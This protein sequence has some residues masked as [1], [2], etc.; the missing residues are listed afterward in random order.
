MLNALT[1]DLEDYFH[2][3]AFAE[4]V[5]SNQ[6]NSCASRLQRNTDKVLALFASKNSKATF[7]VLGWVAERYPALIR[8]IAEQGHEIA[9]HSFQHKL[10][11]ELTAA[12]F[13]E[14]SRKAKALLEDISGTPV[15]GYRS[16]SFSINGESLWAFEI[17]AD[18]GFS[19]DSS[20]FPV[21]HLNYGMHHAARF[22]FLI[23][24]SSGSILEFPMPTLEFSGRRAPFGGGAYFRLLP[25]WYT[26]WA[27]QFVNA[28]EKAPISVYL[29]PWELD[30]EQPRMSG[31]LTARLRHYFGLRGMKRKLRQLLDDFHFCPMGLLVDQLALLGPKRVSPEGV[32]E[33]LGVAENWA[34]PLTSSKLLNRHGLG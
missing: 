33:I 11:Y 23:D 8:H 32:R 29:H 30:P 20:I 14:D 6:W 34:G 3:T 25:Y 19:Y 2:V 4:S 10:V 13:R 21:K 18:L 17:L 5:S 27:I 16:P 15:R 7:F 26:R 24:T 12:K 9:C 28:Q 31:N 22:P 1:V